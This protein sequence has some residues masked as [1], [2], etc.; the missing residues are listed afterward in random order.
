MI[1]F[2]HTIKY[3]KEVDG[4]MKIFLLLLLLFTSSCSKNNNFTNQEIIDIL[5]KEAYVTTLVE[6]EIVISKQQKSLIIYFTENDKIISS[7]FY[8]SQS[9]PNWI[10]SK[11]DKEYLIYDSDKDS[12][13][14]LKGKLI[15]GD[16]Q[17]SEEEI[18]LLPNLIDAY[19][20]FY[21]DNTF[22]KTNDILIKQIEE[23][24]LDYYLKNR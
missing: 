13:F 17:L 3:Q 4:A 7:S 23:A 24:L 20:N 11:E 9:Y 19:E 22:I 5:N 10:L 21:Y 2:Y 18:K 6:D 12:V 8:D 16:G 1:D 15:E 14:D